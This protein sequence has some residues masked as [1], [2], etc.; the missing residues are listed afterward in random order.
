MGWSVADRKD[1]PLYAPKISRAFTEQLKALLDPRIE[2]RE[3]NYHINDEA[4]AGIATDWDGGTNDL[5]L[6][7]VDVIAAEFDD[8][9][10][11]D[12][13]C[14]LV[15]FSSVYKEISERIGQT[16]RRT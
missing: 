13:C 15:F 9:T 12:A 16:D 5:G 3:V 10:L 14:D 7:N 4:F 1:G 11:P 6:A 8:P 2:M